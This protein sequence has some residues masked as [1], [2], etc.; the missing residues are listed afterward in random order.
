MPLLWVCALMCVCVLVCLCADV[1]VCIP[2]WIWATT[3]GSVGVINGGCAVGKRTAAR[4]QNMENA[5]KNYSK[6]DIR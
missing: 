3:E 6:N 4:K 2:E 1:F 5:S